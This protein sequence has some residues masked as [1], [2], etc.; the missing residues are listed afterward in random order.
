[1]SESCSSLRDIRKDA[2]PSELLR[3]LLLGLLLRLKLAKF[4]YCLARIHL[5]GINYAWVTL[6][7]TLCRECLYFNNEGQHREPRLKPVP[8]ERGVSGEVFFLV[9]TLLNM[10]WKNLICFVL[11]SK[12]GC[13]TWFAFECD[14]PPKSCKVSTTTIHLQQPNKQTGKQGSKKNVESTPKWNFNF[15]MAQRAFHASGSTS[16][17]KTFHLEK[18]GFVWW[19]EVRMEQ[20]IY[21]TSCCGGSVVSV[22]PRDQDVV[23]PVLLSICVSRKHF[24]FALNMYSQHQFNGFIMLAVLSA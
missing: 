1:M 17:S 24:I 18:S 7:L 21:F 9:P 2:L 22:V 14:W 10:T 8:L 3:Q 16:H 4:S 13:S 20:K 15:I 5:H 23:G 11:R 6:F 19:N 12:S